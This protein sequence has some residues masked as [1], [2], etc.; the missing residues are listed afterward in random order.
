MEPSGTYFCIDLRSIAVQ[1][2]I[3]AYHGSLVPRVRMF[4]GR[5]LGRLKSRCCFPLATIQTRKSTVPFKRRL[6]ESASVAKENS[7]LLCPA[8]SGWNNHS[9][10]LAERRAMLRDT[11]HKECICCSSCQEPPGKSRG[12][13]ST[14][15]ARF[16]CW[17]VSDRLAKH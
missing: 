13:L 5:L 9:F 8:R 1:V 6:L 2:C 11:G 17:I 4:C 10:Y 3:V 15:S 16:L 12:N 14:Q 7:S